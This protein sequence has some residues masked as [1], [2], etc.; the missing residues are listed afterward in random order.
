[1]GKEQESQKACRKLTLSIRPPFKSLVK[2]ECL[3]HAESRKQEIPLY[4]AR[5]EGSKEGKIR[6]EDKEE[7]EEVILKGY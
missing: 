6:T 7:K 1:M 3:N 4:Q 5:D 2:Q